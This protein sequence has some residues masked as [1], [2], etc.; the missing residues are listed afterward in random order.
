MHPIFEKLND[1]LA[2]ASEEQLSND[3]EELKEYNSPEYGPYIE[4]L[5]DN[6]LKGKSVH[7]A[8]KAAIE[9]H[10]PHS[11]KYIVLFEEPIITAFDDEVHSLGLLEEDWHVDDIKYFGHNIFLYCAN[12]KTDSVRQLI[13]HHYDRYNN[14]DK[15]DGKMLTLACKYLVKAANLY[16][17]KSDSEQ[18]DKSSSETEDELCE[19]YYDTIKSLFKDY[20][21]DFEVSM[22]QGNNFT[23]KVPIQ[24]KL[25]NPSKEIIYKYIMVK[26]HDN[27]F[28]F[29]F[30]VDNTGSYI[31]G[32]DV[33]NTL[34]FSCD[35]VPSDS[36]ETTNTIIRFI[37]KYFIN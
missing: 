10:M 7:W 14:S 17:Q 24:K 15:L 34:S 9:A 5:L 26:Y 29:T 18:T 3:W 12:Y 16:K 2:N 25:A 33:D 35:I 21:S 8:I 27:C 19:R 13:Y 37:E 23:A 11:L 1:Y 4:D 36:E 31:Y 30:V 20:S 28:T 22:Q 32:Y 6:A